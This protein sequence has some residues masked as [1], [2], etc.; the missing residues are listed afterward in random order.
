MQRPDLTIPEQQTQPNKRKASPTEDMDTHK[1]PKTDNDTPEHHAMEPFEPSISMK[2][3][4]SMANS[5]RMKNPNTS[6]AHATTLMHTKS[7][8]ANFA[9]QQ[10]L[11]SKYHSLLFWTNNSSLTNPNAKQPLLLHPAKTHG[12]ETSWPLSKT[13][14][15]TIDPEVLP[16][17][18]AGHLCPTPVYHDHT[19][20][21][22]IRGGGQELFETTDEE[23]DEDHNMDMDQ[24][25]EDLSVTDEEEDDNDD[26]EDME[27]NP[28]TR[29]S[30]RS[31][32]S[33]F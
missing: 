3:S 27:E 18:T 30:T 4:V 11:L 25:P 9:S 16:D 12:V 20:V 21:L 28:Q 31:G 7:T 29:R 15:P 26:D 5:T 2:L 19:P 14:I 1:I 33:R 6:I 32:P 13:T 23:E 17:A 8:R 10:A 22:R 24:P